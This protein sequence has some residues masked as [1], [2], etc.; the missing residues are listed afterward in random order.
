MTIQAVMV[1]AAAA[2]AAAVAAA[3]QETAWLKGLT[4]ESCVPASKVDGEVEPPVRQERKD[5]GLTV[6]A[7]ATAVP[8]TATS[9]NK[10]DEWRTIC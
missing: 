10:L 9:V 7:M 3:A 5:Y 1:A 8:Q 4:K 2:A 6:S